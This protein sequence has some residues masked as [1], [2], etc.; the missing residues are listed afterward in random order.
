M[1][2]S[3]YAQ[4]LLPVY[5]VNHKRTCVQSRVPRARVC[6]NAG[7]YTRAQVLNIISSIEM[8]T[9][10]YYVFYQSG[11]SQ[12]H[13]SIITMTMPCSNV[14]ATTTT[15]MTLSLLTSVTPL[16]ITVDFFVYI[17]LGRR[18]R[19]GAGMFSRAD[20]GEYDEVCTTL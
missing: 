5:S 7:L 6:V 20:V 3:L 9:P 14:I 16:L 1:A 17:V 13:P 8:S 10:Q 12:P 18:C 19:R 4:S 11:Q 15:T 2:L